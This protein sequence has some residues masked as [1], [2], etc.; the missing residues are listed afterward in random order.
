MNF[1]FDSFII[2]LPY[3]KMGNYIDAMLINQAKCQAST[4]SNKTISVN[5]TRTSASDAAIQT[6]QSKGY[7]VSVPAVTE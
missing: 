5:G 1:S 7:T 6:L 2:S 4:S 3:A